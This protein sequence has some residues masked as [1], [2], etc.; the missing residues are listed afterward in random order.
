MDN[1]RHFQRL[2]FVSTAQIKYNHKNYTGRVLDLSPDGILIHPVIHIP[3][4]SGDTC[5]IKVHLTSS[6]V[7]LEFNAELVHFSQNNFGFKFADVDIKTHTYIQKLLN[8]NA[9]FKEPV[10]GASL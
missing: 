2:R 1:K 6:N 4:K 3:I 8:L 9:E 7:T 5:I 10:T